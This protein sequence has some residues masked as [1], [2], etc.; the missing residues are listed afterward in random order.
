MI[1]ESTITRVGG[2][3]GYIA[4]DNIVVPIWG[5]K[6][7]CYGCFCAL[8]NMRP[9]SAWVLFSYILIVA[10]CERCQVTDT[11]SEM[12]WHVGGLFGIVFLLIIDCV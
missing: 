7:E 9:V 10:S 5:I 12:Y 1:C 6:C 2:V 11:C 3:S 4:N 8:Y